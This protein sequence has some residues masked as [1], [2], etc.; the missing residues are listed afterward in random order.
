MKP[1]PLP[2]ALKKPAKNTMR[3]AASCSF[4]HAEVE[5][6]KKLFSMLLAGSDVRTMLRSYELQNVHRK[7]GVMGETIR[8]QNVRRVAKR[9]LDERA[10]AASSREDE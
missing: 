1:L 7:I 6:L 5:V 10:N 3:L 8:R 2:K 4:T 9:L